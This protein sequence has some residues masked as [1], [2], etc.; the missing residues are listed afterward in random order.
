MVTRSVAMKD[1]SHEKKSW[2]LLGFCRYLK[3]EA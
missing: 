2:F 3:S 1:K